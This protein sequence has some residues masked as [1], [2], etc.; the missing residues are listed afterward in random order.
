MARKS[1]HTFV[2]S[3]MNKDLDARLLNAG[4]YRD[5]VNVSVSRSEADDVGALENIIGN[6]FINNLQKSGN[7]PCEIIGWCIDQTNDR[8]FLFLTNFQDNSSDQLSVFAPYESTHKIVYFNTKTGTS[9]TI[10]SGSFL[11]FSINSRINDANMIENL[12][13]WTDNR[14]QPRKINVE[15]AIADASYY[16]N[17]DH[18]SVAKYYPHKAIDLTD[19]YTLTNARLIAQNSGINP[20]TNRYDAIYDF[21]VLADTPSAAVIEALTNNIGLKGYVVGDNGNRWEFKLAWFQQDGGY[22]GTQR[23]PAPYGGKYLVFVDRDLSSGLT[24][25]PLAGAP[26]NYT[27]VFVEET[28][29]DVSSPWLEQ[30]QVKLQISSISHGI[31]GTSIAYAPSA[32]PGNYASSVYAFGTRSRVT[33]LDVNYGSTA[34]TGGAFNIP[35]AFPLNDIVATQ[36]AWPRIKHPKIPEDKYIIAYFSNNTLG[37]YQIICSEL[38]SLEDA[39]AIATPNLITEYGLAVGDIITYHWPNKYYDQQFPGDPA[40]LE[41]KFIRFAYRFKY[42]DG[43]Y[44]IISPFTQNVFIPKQNG[45]FLNEVEEGNELLP[46]EQ[47]A[48]QNTVVDFFE[49]KI[50]QVKLN[51]PLEF[52]A[53][54]LKDKLKVKEIDI[55]YKESDGLSLKVVETLDI[56]DY[57]SV[58][59]N[60]IVY[61]YQS[62][63]PIKTLQSDEITRVYDT[64]PIRA[65][66]Q[67]SSANRIIYGN[68]FDRHTSPLSLNYQVGVSS[69]F[70]SAFTNTKNTDISYPNHTL[71]QN[72]NYQVGIILSDRYGRSTDVIL[73]TVDAQAFEEESGIYANSRISFGGSTVYSPYFDSVTNLFNN[74]QNY[75]PTPQGT[76]TST[77]NPKAG[78][79]DWPGDSLKIRF[80]QSIPS[81]ITSNQGYPGLFRTPIANS[82]FTVTTITAVGGGE[83]SWNINFTAGNDHL[84]PGDVVEWFI[85]TVTAEVLSFKNTG[86][87][88]AEIRVN[89]NG[90][91][92]TTGSTIVSGYTSQNPLGFYSYRFVVK[93]NEQEYYN[94]YLPSLLQGNPVVKP[95]KLYLVANTTSS[96]VIKVDNTEHPTPQTFPI[97]E[98]QL[99][100]ISGVKRAVV[101]I[102]NNEQFEIDTA[103][104]VPDDGAG[105]NIEFQFTTGAFETKLNVATLLTD[106]ANKVPPALNETTPVQQQYSTSETRLIPRVALNNNS[107]LTIPNRPNTS[108]GSWTFPIFPGRTSLKV[109]AI[110]NFEAMFVD[111]KYAGLWQADTDPPTVVVENKFNLGRNSQTALP[112]S[113]E[114]Y[115]AAIYETTPTIS[116]LEIFFESSTSGTIQELNDEIEN[117]QLIQEVEFFNSCWLKKVSTFQPAAQGTFGTRGAGSSPALGVWPLNN[118]YAPPQTYDANSGDPALRSSLTDYNFYLEESRIRGGYNNV[119][120]DLGAR[121]FLDEEEPVQQHR[122]NALI[123]SGLFNSRTGLNRTN[124]FPVGTTITKAAN[125]EYGSIQKI[126]AEETNLLL[127]QENK[128]QRALIDKDTIYTSEGGTQTS[129]PGVVIGQITPYA[130]EYGISKNP[131]SFAIYGYRKYF[132]DRNRNA[133]IRLSHDGITEISEYGM[134]DWFRDNLATLED[135]YLNTYTFPFTVTV[136]TVNQSYFDYAASGTIMQANTLIGSEVFINVGGTFT[137]TGVYVTAITNNKIYLTDKINFA[138]MT[139]GSIKLVSNNRSYVLGGWDIYNKQYVC[140]LQYN[141]TTEYST[142]GSGTGKDYTYYTLGFDEQIN[143]WPSFYTYRPGLLGSIK[144]KYY[145]VNNL[146]DTYSY[147]GIGNF[148]IYEQYKDNVTGTNRGVFYGNSSPSTVTII[149]N[150]NPSIEKNF[151]T[152]DYEGSSGWKVVAAGSTGSP[153]NTAPI[154][155]DQTGEDFYGAAWQYH[156]DKTN[157]VYSLYEGQYDSANPPNTGGAATVQP[158]F[159]VGFNRKENRYVANLVN[160]SDPAP[161]EVIFGDKMSGIKGFYNIVTLSTDAT[162]APGKMKELYQ[163]GLSYNISST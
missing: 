79:I 160:A 134:R 60:F 7:T 29:K 132:I 102:L 130:G 77:E 11:N 109:R 74:Y 103:V 151:L 150:A 67:S 89:Y 119:S 78:I 135:N 98:G 66:T 156:V 105:N 13:F 10:V 93:Q 149:A 35:N 157:Q 14:N 56:N 52:S 18:V 137:A 125:P 12:L 111:G 36:T 99:V 73:S 95:Y 114:K 161:G 26:T 144:N 153:G 122:F 43:E 117:N 70:T 27:L 88:T 163:V 116:N 96:K 142:A 112:F 57:S 138:I 127:F 83:E 47:V 82:S 139:D 101:N 158:I 152:I 3:K 64:V 1:T 81:S 108:S 84:K 128:C 94:D 62:R 19:S 53:N 87:T 38:P 54:Q 143:G 42:D 131:E 136:P 25:T 115:Q 146:Y 55:L 50:T 32:T 133:A 4:E 44:S 24:L 63:K 75:N 28:M 162:T 15:T 69:K 155:S 37:N 141:K 5:G 120:M 148:G 159:H 72:R 140:S 39:S 51:I 58:T 48:G 17:E 22:G 104:T 68:F 91:S 46:Q 23:L 110:G 9:Q 76:I 45:Y 145:T 61:N 100:E 113:K 20:A 40:F 49:N 2:Q 6:E 33:D 129:S 30:D 123:Y 21:F 41:D 65:K 107:S 106:N 16:Y 154:F 80:Q 121:A 126:Y 34:G 86:G 92:P 85:N 71:K 147:T 97:L 118:V 124:E 8:I 59:D 31:F 90:T